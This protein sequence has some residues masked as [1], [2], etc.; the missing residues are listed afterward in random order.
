MG[1]RFCKLYETS[2]AENF[3]MAS[4]T[5]LRL[6]SL[7]ILGAIV[8]EVT[9]CGTKPKH[10]VTALGAVAERLGKRSVDQAEDAALLVIE[11]LLKA[12]CDEDGSGGITFEEINS[13]SCTAA[14]K[15]AFEWDIGCDEGCFAMNDMS[16]DG[17]IDIS[18]GLDD[19]KAIF[20]A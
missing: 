1:T 2:L 18:E 6:A 20:A 4:K 9:G 7:L 5:F 8:Q 15:D 16:G 19:L 3:T 17:E 11:R 10:R 14:L 13:E 12:A